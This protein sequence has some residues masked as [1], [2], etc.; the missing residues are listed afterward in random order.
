MD[1][2][3]FPM[4]KATCTLTFESYSFNVGKVRLWWRRTAEP[5]QM[6]G[7]TQLPDFAMTDFTSDKQSSTQL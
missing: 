3:V 5:V 4:D 6:I 2:T 7:E 1:F